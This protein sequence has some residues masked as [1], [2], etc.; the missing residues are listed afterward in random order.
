MTPLQ[1]FTMAAKKVIF[2][3]EHNPKFMRMMGTKQGAVHLVHVVMAT[4]EKGR[5]IPPD[6]V[7]QLAQ[8]VYLSM[9]HFAHEATGISPSPDVL[10][11]VM[12]DI[13]QMTQGIKPQ[14][15]GIIGQQMGAA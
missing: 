5:H 3:V 4:L 6:I 10:N 15:G 11:A 8:N 9:V 7:D 1:K 2:H 14:A 12:A 13:H